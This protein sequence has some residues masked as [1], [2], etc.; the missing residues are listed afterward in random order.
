MSSDIISKIVNALNELEVAIKSAKQS[1]LAVDGDDSMLKSRIESYE[2]IL[3]RQ[4][5]LVHDLSV[6]MT[7][8]NWPEVARLGELVRGSSL[9]IKVDAGFII[10]WLRNPELVQ[11]QG[12]YQA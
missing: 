7:N 12:D 1:V 11:G 5:G 10:N 8:Q 6:A 9:L 3:R 4:R 2:E